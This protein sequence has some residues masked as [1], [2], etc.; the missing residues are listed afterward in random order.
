MRDLL[1]RR[2][3][4]P[5]RPGPPRW[6]SCG[7]ATT[8][9]PSPAFPLGRGGPRFDLA[10]VPAYDYAEIVRIAAALLGRE[11][12]RQRERGAYDVV[13]VDEYQDNDPKR[14]AA[15]GPGKGLTSN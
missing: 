8:G 9:W 10:P 15:D 13:L 11:Q 7:T 5:G 3:A 1:L 12:T 4:W 2:R 6:A 14:V